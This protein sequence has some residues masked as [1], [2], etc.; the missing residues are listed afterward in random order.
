MTKL[1]LIRKNKKLQNELIEQ[2]AVNEN[3]RNS[4]ETLKLDP[5]RK[6]QA[7][8]LELRK[9]TNA[10]AFLI[11]EYRKSEEISKDRCEELNAHIDSLSLLIGVICEKAKNDSLSISDDGCLIIDMLSVINVHNLSDVVFTERDDGNIY[12][13]CVEKPAKESE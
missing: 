10:D 4:L 11:D 7:E 1:D 12:I 8:L 6:M 13:K 2:K 3:L 5:G 9:R